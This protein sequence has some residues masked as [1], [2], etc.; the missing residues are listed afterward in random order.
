M[1][2]SHPMV[3]NVRREWFLRFHALWLSDFASHA[4][5][6]GLKWK[7]LGEKSLLF[8]KICENI[9]FNNLRAC[10]GVQ[11]IFL[12]SLEGVWKNLIFFSKIWKRLGLFLRNSKSI[13][14][15][16][17]SSKKVKKVQKKRKNRQKIWGL[18]PPEVCCGR[19]ETIPLSSRDAN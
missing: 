5:T 17:K 19:R 4:G 16:S 6:L 10:Q 9:N 12:R 15:S 3:P 18:P 1:N 14:F 7:D 13:F 2:R 11:N 8:H